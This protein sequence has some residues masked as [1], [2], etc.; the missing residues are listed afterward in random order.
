MKGS[1]PTIRVI[2]NGLYLVDGGLEVRRAGGQVVKAPG[3]HALCRCG[4]STNKPFCNGAHWPIG[5]KAP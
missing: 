3:P 1:G 4:G 2:E 5:F